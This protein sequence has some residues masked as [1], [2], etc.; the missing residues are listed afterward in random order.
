[1]DVRMLRYF[2]ACVENRTMHAAARAVNVSQPALSKAVRL[3]ELEL[4]VTL[5]DRQPRGVTPTPYGDTLFR[6]AKMINSEMRHALAELDA[7]RGMTRGTIVVGVITTL[8][9]VMGEVTRQTMIAHPGLKLRLRVGFSV[10]LSPALLDGELDMAILLLSRGSPPPGLQFE[11]LIRTGPVVVVRAGHPLAHGGKVSL[12]DLS[13]Y[14]WLIPE[15]P[16][17]HREIVQRAFID[18]GLPAPLASVEVSTVIFFTKL[19]QESDLITVV[20]ATL[21]NARGTDLGLVELDT[22][23]DFPPE[24]VGLAFRDN[25]T[26]LPGA[27]A[28][29][30]L[31]RDVFSRLPGAI[32]P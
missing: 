18:A 10:E 9:E 6:Y 19:I 13:G 1:M 26:I 32:S 29:T 21:L 20:P 22:D 8:A 12:K 5:L 3:L 15:Y 7:M 28:V 24:S 25:S 14:P 27:R 11:P 17:S 30:S 2:V 4:G 23:L 16:P 31:I